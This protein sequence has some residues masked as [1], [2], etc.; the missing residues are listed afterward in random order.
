MFKFIVDTQ[1]PPKLS[2][3]LIEKGFDSKHTIGFPDGHL[4]KD[5]KIIQ[6]AK[7][8]TR[9]ILTKDQDF[10]DHYLIKG[11]PPKII[12]LQFGNISN[13]QLLALFEANL[14]AIHAMLEGGAEMI[15]FSRDQIVEYSAS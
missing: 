3:Y 8:E 15:L 4:L 5:A 2:K 13:Q 10:F 7:E 12:Q 6:I 1:L 14:E 11:S 9:I